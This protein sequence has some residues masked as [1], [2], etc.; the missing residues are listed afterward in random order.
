MLHISM[1]SLNQRKPIGG[2]GKHRVVGSVSGLAD[3]GCGAAGS[4][5][6]VKSS[7]C[8]KSFRVG[9]LNVGT[10]KGKASEVV[11]TVSR[12]RVDLCCLQETRWKM[13]GIKQIVGKESHY[14][15]FWSGNE[16]G[17]GGV[18]VLLAEEWWEKVFEVVRVSDRIQDHSHSYDHWQDSVCVCKCVYTSSKP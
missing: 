15:L 12:R 3:G 18:G 10:I 6:C 5:P 16:D 9:T 2:A 14:K 11:E 1:A 8:P 17:T 7:K 13:E 4:G